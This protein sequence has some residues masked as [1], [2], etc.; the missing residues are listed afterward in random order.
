MCL[1]ISITTKLKDNNNASNNLS[2]KKREDSLEGGLDRVL[3][4]S[5]PKT[6]VPSLPQNSSNINIEC[7]RKSKQMCS[8]CDK[9]LRA[10][11]NV[12]FII[13]ICLLFYYSEL[14]MPAVKYVIYGCSF[15]EKLHELS[16]YR[17]FKL[18]EKHCCSCY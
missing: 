10:M 14:I 9:L 1:N 8:L 15:R 18:E 12:Y 7:T 13:L 5:F 16:L 6:L 3:L 11:I 2:H 17:S 4:L